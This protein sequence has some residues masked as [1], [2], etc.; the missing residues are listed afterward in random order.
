MTFLLG[1]SG[2]LAGLIVGHGL[3]TRVRRSEWEREDKR[4]LDRRE[5]AKRLEFL[6]ELEFIGSQGDDLIVEL[7]ALIINKG[8]VDHTIREFEFDLRCMR[9]GESATAVGEHSDGQVLFPHV[10]K[11]GRWLP[12]EWSSGTFI[13]PGLSTRYSYVTSVASSASF[14]LLHGRFDYGDGR[15]HT[16]ERVVAVPIKVGQ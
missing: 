7:V 2:P 16:A 5:D 13:E 9:H 8:L 12:A 4:R 10:L 1:I 3:S 6:V 14:L 11:V 15:R